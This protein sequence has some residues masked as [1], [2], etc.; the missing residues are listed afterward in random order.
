LGNV[1]RPAFSSIEGDDADRIA[2]LPGEEVLNYGFE[3]AGLIVRFAPSPANLPKIIGHQKNRLTPPGTMEGV[4]LDLR[5]RYHDSYFDEDSSWRDSFLARRNEDPCLQLSK[6][7]R[8]A[9]VR[10]AG[11]GAGSRIRGELA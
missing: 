4:Q 10:Y 8:E 6:M 11:V 1:F 2:V 3:V 5:I 7:A 9:W